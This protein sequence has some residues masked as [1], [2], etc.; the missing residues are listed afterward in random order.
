MRTVFALFICLFA[1]YGTAL[2]TGPGKFVVVI[3][4]G[5]GGRDPGAVR[6]KYQEKQINLA[7]ALLLGDMIEQN[8]KDVQVVY[9]RKKDVFVPLIQRCNI[10]NKANAHLF[11]SIHTNSTPSSSTSASGADTYILGT[12]KT[13]ENL[14]VAKRENSVILY[15][16]DYKTTYGGFDPNSPTSSILFD[17]MSEK[18]ME[19][20][21]TFA[22]HVQSGIKRIANRTDRGVRQSNILVLNRNSRPS[23]L[24]ELG[25]INNPV[26]AKYLYSKVGQRA[27]ASA[28]YDGFRKYKY[29]YDKRMNSFTYNATDSKQVKN[30]QQTVIIEPEPVKKAVRNDEPVVVQREE[31]KVEIINTQP[32]TTNKVV[33]EKT[34]VSEKSASRK[35]NNL[36]GKIEYRVQFLVSNK[37]LPEKS[38]QFKGLTSV[39]Y[40]KEG[41]TYKYTYGS[42]TDYNEIIKLQQQV[43]TKFKDAFVIKFKDGK[44]IK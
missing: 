30:V 38:S 34:A 19:Q 5:H 15:E 43:R 36:A 16:D 21:H 9:T 10:A 12:D 42:T 37:V 3:D 41:T 35:T 23:V 40:Y 44:R 20:S 1:L 26:E 31:N 4:A 7:V 32:E 17:Y 24:I 6:G 8:I 29:D 33:I 18:Y 11:I 27:L 14:A 25:F 2:A 13:A 28:I 39:K 22:T